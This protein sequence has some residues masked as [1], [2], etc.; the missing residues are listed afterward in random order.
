V[1][2]DGIEE[3][4]RNLHAR[5]LEW[6]EQRRALQEAEERRAEEARFRAELE[7]QI[8]AW[9]L[10]RDIRA[11]VADMRSL[12]ADAAEALRSEPSQSIPGA[13]LP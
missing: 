3:A 6:E 7:R 1:L 12:T 10:V 11:F 8:E 9:R 2:L 4:A 13:R 5:R